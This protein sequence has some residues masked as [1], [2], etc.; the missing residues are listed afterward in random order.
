[1]DCIIDEPS[2][3]PYRKRFKSSF[4]QFASSEQSRSDS[5]AAGE[6]QTPGS[7]GTVQMCE[8]FISGLLRALGSRILGCFSFQFNASVT[9]PTPEMKGAG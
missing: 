5:R 1:V 7:P 9:F 4:Q 3:M 8:E 6:P 2:I